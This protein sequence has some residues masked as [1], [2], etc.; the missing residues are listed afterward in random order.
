[1]ANVIAIIKLVLSLVPVILE[2]V[3]AVEAALP[4][5]GQGAAKLALV[6]TTVQAAFD[7]AGNAVA[8]FEQVW[9]ALEKT[10]GAVVGLFNT[11]GVFKK[12]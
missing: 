2:T 10:I 12:G 11:T 5:S 7:V 6:R 4:Q 9:P 8:T 3:K 1:M